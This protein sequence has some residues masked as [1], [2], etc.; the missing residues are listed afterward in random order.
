MNEPI[1]AGDQCVIMQSV[2]PDNLGKT[3]VAGKLCAS[4]RLLGRIIYIHGEELLTLSGYKSTA[5]CP[6]QWLRKLNEPSPSLKQ[7]LEAL[8]DY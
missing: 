2:F 5:T 3:I 7:L 1:K 4:S 8:E 6:V